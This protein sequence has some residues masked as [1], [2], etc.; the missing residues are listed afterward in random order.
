MW[1]PTLFFLIDYRLASDAI[2]GIHEKSSPLSVFTNPDKMDLDALWKRLLRTKAK[3][4]GWTWS[5]L[6]EPLFLASLFVPIIWTLISIRLGG[7]RPQDVN[8]WQLGSNAAAFVVILSLWVEVKK[9]NV[10]AAE[11][12]RKQL[13]ELNKQD[14]R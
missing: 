14:H 9:A 3:T 13:E 5:R 1:L 11:A 10:R 4:G 7:T 12:I 6:P 2:G 8:W